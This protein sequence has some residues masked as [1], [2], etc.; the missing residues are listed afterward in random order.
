MLSAILLANFNAGSAY[1]YVYSKSAPC[2]NTFSSY[3]TESTTEAVTENTTDIHTNKKSPDT[4]DHSAEIITGLGILLF[5]SFTRIY[6]KKY[7]RKE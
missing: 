3:S 2:V 1:G 7:R 6:T 5:I 4:G